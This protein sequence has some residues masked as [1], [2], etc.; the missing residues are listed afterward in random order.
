[1]EK[2]QLTSSPSS[3]A[4]TKTCEDQAIAKLIKEGGSSEHISISN[5]F[6][7]RGLPQNVPPF[8][9]K[10]KTLTF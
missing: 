9:E 3:I 5:F 4:P 2:F 6:V 7:P 1:M 10:V 8:F